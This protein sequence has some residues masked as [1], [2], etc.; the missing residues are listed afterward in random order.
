MLTFALSVFNK[1]FFPFS[2]N[3]S[4]LIAWSHDIW[5]SHTNCCSPWPWELLRKIETSKLRHICCAFK[6]EINVN[7][8]RIKCKRKW[9]FMCLCP[10]YQLTNRRQS[11]SLVKV[12]VFTFK[13]QQTFFSKVSILEAWST[14]SLMYVWEEK[15][16]KKNKKKKFV[17]KQI[18]VQGRKASEKQKFQL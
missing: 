15:K 10:I 2:I 14:F 16:S 11:V 7:Y 8:R 5:C 18:A 1:M 17:E 6:I 3:L 4:I 9:K 12:K 13:L